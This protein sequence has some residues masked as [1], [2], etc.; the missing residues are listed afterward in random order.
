MFA[1]LA[2]S[3][4]VGFDLALELQ[5]IAPRAALKRFLYYVAS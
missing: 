5:T 2:H 3:L 1:A 4:E